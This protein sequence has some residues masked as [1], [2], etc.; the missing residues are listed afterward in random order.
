MKLDVINIYDYNY[1]QIIIL[2]ISKL[3]IKIKIKNIIIDSIFYYFKYI[4]SIVKIILNLVLTN[5]K[6][7]LAVLKKQ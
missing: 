4:L 3:K 7:S 1:Y 2:L 5:A 6:M